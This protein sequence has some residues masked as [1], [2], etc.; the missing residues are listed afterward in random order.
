M[1]CK[2]LY[3]DGRESDI[4]YNANGQVGEL[5]DPGNAVTQFWYDS[6]GRLS[7][8]RSPLS[9]DAV[10]DGISADDDTSRTVVSYDSSNRATSV[11]LPKAQPTDS[12]QSSHTYTY[13]SSSETQLNIAGLTP[14]SGYARRREL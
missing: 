1:L 12:Y 2:V 7:K 8:V 13:V 3:W 4:F 10:A 14:A 9:A 11:T 6:S 5:L